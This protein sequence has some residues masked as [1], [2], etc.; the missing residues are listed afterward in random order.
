VDFA[1]VRAA[2]RRC[3]TA[4]T[5]PSREGFTAFNARKVAKEIA[6]QNGADRIDV[7][8]ELRAWAPT[9]G[10]C[11]KPQATDEPPTTPRPLFLYV[12]DRLVPDKVN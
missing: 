10:G 6:A 7:L 2:L 8:F 4:Q 12:P 3:R 11:V 9:V 5:A 1:E